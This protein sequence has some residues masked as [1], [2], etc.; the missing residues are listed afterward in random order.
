MALC[1]L[2]RRRTQNLLNLG[3]WEPQPFHRGAESLE[4]L[5]LESGWF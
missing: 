5:V 1:A 4:N 2:E 3:S